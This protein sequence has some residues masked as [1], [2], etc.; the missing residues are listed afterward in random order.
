M[1]LMHSVYYFETSLLPLRFLRIEFVDCSKS[2]RPFSPNSS[3]R[4]G[5]ASSNCSWLSLTVTMRLKLSNSSCASTSAI[6]RLVEDSDSIR[7]GVYAVLSWLWNPILLFFTGVSM[8]RCAAVLPFA[9][10]WGSP[11]FSARS[12]CITVKN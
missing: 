5:S 9:S 12:I 6:E 8:S 11:L 10:W 7:V 4:Y 3:L 2:S 1:T